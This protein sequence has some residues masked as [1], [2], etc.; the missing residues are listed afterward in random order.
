MKSVVS[1]HKHEELVEV[2]EKPEATAVHNDVPVES[3]HHETQEHDH[4][5]IHKASASNLEVD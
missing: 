4:Q 1:E 3:D 2:E 5:S